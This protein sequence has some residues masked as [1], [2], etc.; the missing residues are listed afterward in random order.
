MSTVKLK[1]NRSFS[2]LLPSSE[3]PGHNNCISKKPF[4][5]LA[6][7]HYTQKEKQSSVKAFFSPA[8]TNLTLDHTTS[9]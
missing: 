2:V 1:K 6:C 3:N 8:P 5:F 7:A 9:T 4:G